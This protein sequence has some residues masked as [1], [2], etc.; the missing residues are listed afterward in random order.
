LI[1]ISP[2]ARIDLVY[3]YTGKKVETGPNKPHTIHIYNEKEEKYKVYPD[4]QQ[5]GAIGN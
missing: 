3:L 5:F 4:K 1:T 2:D